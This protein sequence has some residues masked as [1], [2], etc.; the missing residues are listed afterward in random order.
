[1]QQ[2][3][4]A[5]R[6]GAI[7]GLGNVLAKAIGFLMVPFYTHYLDPVDYGVLE[8]LALSMSL[9]GM[10]LHMGITAALL[11]SYGAAQ[12]SD[13]KR[14]AVSTAF[15]FVGVTGLVTFLAGAGFV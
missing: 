5:V 15:L 7:Y 8:I 2:I 1:T 12:S 4:T 11:R 14:K 13:E 3:H 9:L 6:H 10:V